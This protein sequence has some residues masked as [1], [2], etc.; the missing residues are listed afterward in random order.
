MEIKDKKIIDKYLNINKLAI[1]RICY[2]KS[3]KENFQNSIQILDINKSKIIINSHHKL[4]YLDGFFVFHSYTFI[5]RFLTKLHVEKE[6]NVYSCEIP[7]KIETFDQRKHIRFFYETDERKLI[8]VFIDS[9]KIKISVIVADIS[10][11]GIGLII[12]DEDSIPVTGDILSIKTNILGLEIDSLAKV[13]NIYGNKAGCVF[14]D[15]SNKFQLNLNQVIVEE[16]EWRSET[17][18]VQLKKLYLKKKQEEEKKKE[19]VQKKKIDQ[20]FVESFRKH[21]VSEIKE[22]IGV[23]LKEKEILLLEHTIPNFLSSIYFTFKFNGVAFR[24][25]FYMGEHAVYK[26]AKF[27]FKKKPAGFVINANEILAEIGT[28]FFDRSTSINKEK[29]F[30]ISSPSV[31]QSNKRLMTFLFKNPSIKILFTT[32]LG[33]ATLLLLPENLKN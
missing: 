11:G 19:N 25:F 12:K 7:E 18:L 26:T 8:S 21:F 10:A 31:I 24:A 17:L 15:D 29:D 1:S 4:K 2:F 20:H 32:E 14:L 3:N 33:E 9:L 16:V 23:E 5:F 30:S 22:I 6:E 28:Q 13:I 27:V